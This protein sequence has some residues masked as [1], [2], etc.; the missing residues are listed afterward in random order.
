MRARH[1]RLWLGGLGAAGIAIAHCLAYVMVEPQAHARHHLLESSG[2]RYWPW[3]LALAAG[4]LVAGVAGGIVASIRAG[5]QPLSDGRVFGRAVIR[6]VPAQIVLFVLIEW[7]ERSTAGGL[8]IEQLTAPVF[9][10]GVICQVVVAFV[11]AAVVVMLSNAVAAFVR[12][13]RGGLDSPSASPIIFS[14]ADAI[15]LRP[16]VAVG[17][18]TLRGPPRLS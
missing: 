17:G 15:V 3:L 8:S 14:S 12:R 5:A 4:A 13:T 9:L 10:V 6:L 16:L 11:G 18:R 7:L 1:E 2:H